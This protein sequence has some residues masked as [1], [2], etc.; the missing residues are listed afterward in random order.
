LNFRLAQCWRFRLALCHVCLRINFLNHEQFTNLACESSHLRPTE[1]I[2]TLRTLF[3]PSLTERTFWT[4]AR[5]ADVILA[6]ILISK[7]AQS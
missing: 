6:N 2:K 5:A 1:K 3:A 4:E 7:A